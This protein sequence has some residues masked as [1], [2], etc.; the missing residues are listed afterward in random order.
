MWT[1][2]L[3]YNKIS[4]ISCAVENCEIIKQD[5]ENNLASQLFTF[6]N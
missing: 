6:E 3:A 5:L 2:N 1:M 4:N